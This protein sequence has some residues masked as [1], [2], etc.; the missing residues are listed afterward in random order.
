MKTL[1]L[2]LLRQC[3]ATLCMTV[4]VFTF[5]LIAGNLLKEVLGLLV[6]G[7]VSLFLVIKSLLLLIPWV[8]AFALP[9][10]MLMSGLM[11]FGRFSADQEYTAARSA[12]ISLLSL[13]SP[14][15]VL[16]LL[17]TGVCA[18][19]NLKISPSSRVAYKQIF[20]EQ[21]TNLATFIPEGRYIDFTDEFVLYVSKVRGN[22]LF[23]IR[24][25]QF[26]KG[27]KMLD[28]F[29]KSGR[30]IHEEG[31]DTIRL[32]LNEARV[33]TRV[34]GVED[35]L[36]EMESA[37]K[38][39]DPEEK[40]ASFENEWLP[41]YLEEYETED[42]PLNIRAPR[43]AD[44]SDMTLSQMLAGLKEARE[45][46]MDIRPYIKEIHHQTAFSFACI[47]FILVAIPLSLKA[48]RRETNIS[49]AMALIVLL[50]YY[51]FFILGDAL[52]ETSDPALHLWLLYWIPNFLFQGAGLFLLWKANRGIG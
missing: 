13:V 19:F 10:S 50:I 32:M 39:T 7:Q 35:V 14:V 20:A 40:A 21:L 45:K 15:L 22:N 12:G 46:G 33:L 1:H 5:V 37:E 6:S 11:V 41:L 43:K 2:Y 16:A 48:Q 25:Y 34:S 28:V 30:L 3:L 4:M 8:M 24:F 44:I 52:V 18:W 31:D 51:S 17:M 23:N 47:S 49:L 42:I 36:E 26:S 27:Q 9:I 29:A 38:K